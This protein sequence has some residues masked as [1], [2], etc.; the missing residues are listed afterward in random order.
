MGSTREHVQLERS[1]LSL[2]LIVS[3]SFPFLELVWVVKGESHG[4]TGGGNKTYCYLVLLVWV[5]RKGDKGKKKKK[6]LG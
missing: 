2:V 6:C 5:R 3:S 4:G 1:G